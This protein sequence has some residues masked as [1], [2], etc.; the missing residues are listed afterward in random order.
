MKVMADIKANSALLLFSGG[1]DSATCLAWALSRYDYIETVGFEY[2]QRHNVEMQSR[3]NVLSQ[4]KTQFPEWR[5][6][7]G[8]DHIIDLSRSQKNWVGRP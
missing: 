2:A 1:Q 8:E 7:I 6:K 5:S 3:L 4:F